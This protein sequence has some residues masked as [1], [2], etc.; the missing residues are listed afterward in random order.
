MGYKPF[1]VEFI[2]MVTVGLV[3]IVTMELF[4]NYSL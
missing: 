4:N 3:S 1:V 2:A